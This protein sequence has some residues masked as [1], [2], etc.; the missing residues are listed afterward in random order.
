MNIGNGDGVSTCGKT[1]NFT[2]IILNTIAPFISERSLS[3]NDGDFSF[4]CSLTTA[5]DIRALDATFQVTVF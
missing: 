3:T 5:T 4:T 2:F 1:L